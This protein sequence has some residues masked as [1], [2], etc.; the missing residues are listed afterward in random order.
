MIRVDIMSVIRDNN[1]PVDFSEEAKK[2]L[3][4]IPSEVSEEEK[5]QE[6]IYVI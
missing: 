2:Q 6:K 5:K 1:L 4:Y 3:E